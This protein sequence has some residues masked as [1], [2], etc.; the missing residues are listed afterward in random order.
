MNLF[1]E[2]IRTVNICDYSQEQVEAWAQDAVDPGLWQQTLSERITF[3]A[4]VESNIA[5]FGGL[6]EDGYIKTM[7][8]IFEY[9]LRSRRRIVNV[10]N[11]L[12]LGGFK[13]VNIVSVMG[14]GVMHIL[15][16]TVK[17]LQTET[18]IPVQLPRYRIVELK[19]A[20]G[21]SDC[22]AYQLS[23]SGTVSGKSWSQSLSLPPVSVMRQTATETVIWEKGQSVPQAIN[24]ALRGRKITQGTPVTT[25]ERSK[26]P[27]IVSIK[28]P[29]G[30]KKHPDDL[31]DKT[32]HKSTYFF[33]NVAD[34]HLIEVRTAYYVNSSTWYGLDESIAVFPLAA[35]NIST[36]IKGD[37]TVVVGEVGS[38][39]TDGLG[40]Q[41]LRGFACGTD[42]SLI[43]LRSPTAFSRA[44]A[45][46]RTGRIVGQ[47]AT[48][49]PGPMTYTSKKS[50][51]YRACVW[52]PDEGNSGWKAP[53]IFGV[54]GG[55]SE[56]VAINASE[57]V[58]GYT[59]SGVGGAYLWEK[60]DGKWTT[61]NL[62]VL[63]FRSYRDDGLYSGASDI[64]DSGQIVGYSTDPK[65]YENPDSRGK[66][67]HACLWERDTSGE[68]HIS[69]LN[70]AIASK[71]GWELVYANKINNRGEIIVT[72]VKNGKKSPLLLVPTV[73]E[74]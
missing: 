18:Q 13:L 2:T 9:F 42:G 40:R 19:P 61:K 58:V 4:K 66:Q 47:V 56:A 22:Q 51:S 23:D 49:P 54:L 1:Y 59:H 38:R 26:L 11:T 41:R 71:S 33:M 24:T 36:A 55:Q 72:G 50:L 69:D 62:G 6:E 5:G 45:V 34:D 3:V 68:Y 67:L 32:L 20:A 63:P 8:E 30:S 37:K 57:Q 44:V 17:G 60:R 27:V 28:S 46:S 7:N 10:N 48:L 65:W 12:H 15:A 73:L 64:N 16:D 52:Y 21:K 35:T 29:S 70:N 39:A 74:Q 43:Y 31:K 25:D 14:L 53:V